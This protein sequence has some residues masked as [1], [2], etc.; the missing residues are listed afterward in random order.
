MR[1]GN[2]IRRGRIEY[3]QTS[4]LESVIKWMSGQYGH[5]T[6]ESTTVQRTVH[7]SEDSLLQHV[8]QTDPHDAFVVELSSD[9]VVQKLLGA[10]IPSANKT[11]ATS[12]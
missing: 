3:S 1:D 5:H 10:R 4:R 12:W 9:G 11:R 2:N 7:P 6:T 8:I